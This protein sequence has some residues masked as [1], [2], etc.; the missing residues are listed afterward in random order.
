MIKDK[1]K[2]ILITG[3]AGYIGTHAVEL[4][5]REGYRIRIIDNLTYGDAGVRPFLGHKNYEFIKGNICH[6]ED[7][8]SA[9]R[10]VYAVIDL[11]AIVGDPACNK[12]HEKTLSINYEAT[13]VLIEIA[14]YSKVQRFIFASTCSVYGFQTKIA[15]EL[16]KPKPLSIYAE[17]KLKSEEVILK[18]CGNTIP[19][20]FRLA[21]AYGGSYRM[22]FDLVLGIMTIKAIVEKNIKV[23]GGNQYRPLVHAYDAALGFAH[24]LRAPKKRVNK[25]IFNLGSTSQNYTIL[26]LANAI[27]RRFPEITIINE[28]QTTDHRSYKVNF[29][30][31]AKVLGYKTERTIFDGMDEVEMLYKNNKITN[32]KDD[33]Y[34]NFHYLYR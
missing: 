29:N 22:R 13:K 32:Y 18:N 27:K 2:T 28:K 26:E 16:S 9:M 7:V 30:K 15:T 23:Y 14:K 12:D 8:V 11:A 24:A 1:P 4:L 21:T 3:G 20:I 10:G 17:S 33:I 31:V 6:I 5:L 25:Q 34:Y 19:T